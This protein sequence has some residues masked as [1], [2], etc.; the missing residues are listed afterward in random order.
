MDL[1]FGVLTLSFGVYALI[2]GR[3]QLSKNYVLEGN[4]AKIAGL[5][6]V[7]APVIGGIL[8]L[9]GQVDS[10]IFGC[11]CYSIIGVLAFVVFQAWKSK[12][13]KK[14]TLNIG[15]KGKPE[16]DYKWF[17]E[18]V[19]T[20]YGRLNHTFVEEENREN[21]QVDIITISKDKGKWLVRCIPNKDVVSDDI[22]GDFYS[23][24]LKKKADRGVI[25][26]LGTFES[27]V[28]QDRYKGVEVI[29]GE[30]FL[31]YYKSLKP[32]LDSTDASTKHSPSKY[33][34][35]YAASKFA[36][37]PRK[38][39]A[40]LTAEGRAELRT[41]MSCHKKT[42]FPTDTPPC[43][44]ALI[45]QHCGA[46][47]IRVSPELDY[48]RPELVNRVFGYQNRGL[49]HANCPWCNKK[50]YAITTTA[51]SLFINYYVCS[52]PQNPQALFAM[53]VDCVHCNN[54]FWIE[55]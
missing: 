49:L 30:Q 24:M 52:E 3:L 8:T 41:C 20:Y 36:M 35:D 7:I 9:N 12:K 55:W 46:P 6:L 2:K 47:L 38:T 40:E 19:K 33:P 34:R 32:A 54:E 18:M 22:L 21:N 14:Q 25:I 5:L 29:G 51:N 42:P 37:E 39:M 10:A 31:T 16:I 4:S 50:N 27:T 17:V 13:D 53:Q 23:T 11:S 44:I 15:T 43:A 48:V 28:S 26:T 45:C 1:I